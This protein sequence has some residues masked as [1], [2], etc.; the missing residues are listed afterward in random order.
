MA[1]QLRKQNEEV[2]D[3]L[4]KT[5]VDWNDIGEEDGIKFNKL[6]RSPVIKLDD[7]NNVQGIRHSIPQRDSVFLTDLKNVK[8]WYR[9][10]RIFVDALNNDAAKFKLEPGKLCFSFYFE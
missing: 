2:F 1:E 5:N 4:S 3:I 8:P 6:F 10:L 9:A 7:E